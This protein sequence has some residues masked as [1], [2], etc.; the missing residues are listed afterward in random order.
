MLDIKI[1]HPI[2][3]DDKEWIEKITKNEYLEICD[4]TFE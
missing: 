1:F 2:T 3:M 4:Q